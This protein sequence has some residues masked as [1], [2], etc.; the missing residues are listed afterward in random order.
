MR[1]QKIAEHMEIER[2]E[3][4]ELEKKLEHEK[5][6]QKHRMREVIQEQIA[7]KEA[8]RDEANQEYMKEKSQVEGLVKRIQEEDEMEI[9]ARKMKQTE[10]KMIL[11]QWM[12]E[13]QARQQEM[14]RKEKEEND[15]IEA[16]AADKRNM[17]ETL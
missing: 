7:H 16:Y 15:K 9:A 11:E 13:R 2:M 6:K 3:H 5:A 12:A 4:Q 14:I 10:Q 17:E 1:E 8:L